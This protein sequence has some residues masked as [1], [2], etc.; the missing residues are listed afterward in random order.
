MPFTFAHPAIVL[1]FGIK[2]SKYLDFTALVIYILS[3]DR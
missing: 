1:P 3:Q 2:K